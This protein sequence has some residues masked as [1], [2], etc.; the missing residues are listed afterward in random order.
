M[1]VKIQENVLGSV[2]SLFLSQLVSF[3]ADK[4]VSALNSMKKNDIEWH[5]IWKKSKLSAGLIN[6]VLST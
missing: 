3:Q 6:V 4:E 1:L 5:S 2:R